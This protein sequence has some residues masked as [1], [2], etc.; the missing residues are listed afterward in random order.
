MADA[1][2]PP[3]RGRDR[4]FLALMLDI[5]RDQGRWE[6]DGGAGRDVTAARLLLPYIAEAVRAHEEL[7][8]V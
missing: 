5:E 1:P 6:D 4:Y 8:S 7:D 3:G 2:P